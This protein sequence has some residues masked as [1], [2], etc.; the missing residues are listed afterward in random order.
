MKKNLIYVGVGVLI[1][2]FA[3]IA[4]FLHISSDKEYIGEV[5]GE[6]ITKAEYEYFLASTK[7]DIEN[8]SGIVDEASKKAFWQSQA[9]I[10]LVKNA[11]LDN[12]KE[13]KVQIIKADELGI[14]LTDEDKDELEQRISQLREEIIAQTGSIEQ[15]NEYFK[16]AYR[17]TIDEYKSI[18]EELRLVY[19]FINIQKDEIEVQEE[20]LKDFYN[21]NRDEF[22]SVTVRHILISTESLTEEEKEEARNTADMLLY[23]VNSG[24]DMEELVTEYSQ[25]PGKIQN[26]GIY[27]VEARS[28]FV[29]EFKQWALENKVDATEI[30]ETEFGYHVMRVEKRTEF[31]DLRTM[32]EETVKLNKYYEKL[33]E[34]KS[35]PR[36]NLLKNEDVLSR[37]EII[38]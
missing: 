33:E 9:A 36:F 12:L 29:P 14:S 15:A 37:I 38:K 25:D 13:M 11:T 2:V 26:N 27:E 3:S 8:R 34:W 22:D 6:R 20:E 30:V 24:E 18:L 1:L 7:L 31:N 4:I 17:I 21:K 16:N 10:D 32:V 28:N 35:E 19:K 5:A 23:R